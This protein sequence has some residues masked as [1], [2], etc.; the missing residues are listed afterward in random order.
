MQ[1]HDTGCMEAIHI[2]KRVIELAQ[3][4][5]TMPAEVVELAVELNTVIDA[6]SL[7][8]HGTG[9]ITMEV[10]PGRKIPFIEWTTRKFRNL[11]KLIN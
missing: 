4:L 1:C 5:D 9:K 6:I 3:K 8:G 11:K 10:T 2:P 7:Y